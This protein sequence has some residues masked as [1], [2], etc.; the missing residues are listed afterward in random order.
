MYPSPFSSALAPC[1][2]L[3]PLTG[4]PAGGALGLRQTSWTAPGRTLTIAVS[5]ETVTVHPTGERRVLEESTRRK[6]QQCL[7]REERESERE[8]KDH[9]RCC[10]RCGKMGFKDALDV[11]NLAFCCRQFPSHRAGAP[12]APTRCLSTTRLSSRHLSSTRLGHVLA[13]AF[14]I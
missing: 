14:F 11:L 6:H 3:L 1:T 8:I 13:L 4:K 10:W 12:S 2:H 7:G 9:G 5:Q